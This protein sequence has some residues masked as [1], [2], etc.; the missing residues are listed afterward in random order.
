[1][2]AGSGKKEKEVREPLQKETKDKKA[3]RLKTE[4]EE[5]LER[6]KAQST[7]MSSPRKEGGGTL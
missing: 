2:A 1:M 7:P 5:R 6:N 3:E 4:R